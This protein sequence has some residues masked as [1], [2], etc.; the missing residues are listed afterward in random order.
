MLRIIWMGIMI[1]CGE[2]TGEN[3]KRKAEKYGIKLIAEEEL[4]RILN[5]I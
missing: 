3:K 2:N 4:N 1:S 5:D